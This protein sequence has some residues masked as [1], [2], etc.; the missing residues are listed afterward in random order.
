LHATNVSSGAL[1]CSTTGE[2]NIKA[3]NR[4]DTAAHRKRKISISNDSAGGRKHGTQL[5]ADGRTRFVFAAQQNL[6]NSL[7]TTGTGGVKAE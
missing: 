4:F 7:K 2:E 1:P 5:H 3:R 6:N